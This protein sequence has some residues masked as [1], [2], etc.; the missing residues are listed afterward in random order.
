L[1]NNKELKKIGMK[2]AKVLS[3]GFINKVFNLDIDEFLIE[4]SEY[5]YLNEA[6]QMFK[7]LNV[8]MK[9]VNQVQKDVLK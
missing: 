8:K 9:N 7:K 1:L 6:Y 4:K 3:I 2:V 5:K